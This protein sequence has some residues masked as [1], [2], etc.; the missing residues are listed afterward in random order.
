MKFHRGI[1]VE[2]TFETYLDQKRVKDLNPNLRTFIFDIFGPVDVKEKVSCK[3]IEGVMKPDIA[4]TVKGVTKYVSVKTG[5][6][7]A[8]HEE[9][10]KSFI[11]YLRL[12]GVSSET[13]KTILYYQYGDMTLDGSGEKR[14]E[15]QDLRYILKDRIKK[16]NEEFDKDKELM[17]EIVMRCLFKGAD[18]NNIEAD[19]IYDGNENYGVAVSQSQVLQYL[20]KKSFSYMEN[21]HIGPLQY[22]PHAR[23]VKKAI[24]NEKRRQKI[25]LHWANLSKDLEYIYDRF[26]DINK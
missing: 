9:L 2:N 10:I 14:L 1:L 23:Y 5:T 25:I 19:Y 21:P 16:A 13:Q 24:Y 20:R 8:V 6:A 12:L 18:E 22:R 26:V 4:I 15:Y 11:L 7:V 17:I 3:R